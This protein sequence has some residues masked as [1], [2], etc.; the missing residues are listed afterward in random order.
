MTTSHLAAELRGG[1]ITEPVTARKYIKV[2]V[3]HSIFTACPEKALLG[4]FGVYKPGLS[5]GPSSCLVK[6]LPSQAPMMDSLREAMSNPTTMVGNRDLLRDK[7]AGL[8]TEAQPDWDDK[9][10]MPD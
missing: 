6:M 9:S 3:D 8:F 7:A 4:E 1:Y 10:S 2:A 5:R